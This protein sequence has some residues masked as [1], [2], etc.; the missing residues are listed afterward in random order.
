M[1]SINKVILIGHVGRPPEVRYTANG[2]PVAN[3]SLAT[4]DVWT[5]PTGKKQE[6]TEWHRIVVWA[7]LAEFCQQYIT[8]GMF[9]WVEGSIQ[10]RNWQDKDGTPRTTYEIRARDVAILEPKKEQEGTPKESPEAAP[11]E[12]TPILEDDIPF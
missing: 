9:I 5:D 4:T 12:E 10:S 2:V 6:K 8:K 7:K 3:F 11:H 1:R